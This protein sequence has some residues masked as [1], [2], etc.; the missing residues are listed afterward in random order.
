MDLFLE[1]RSARQF[2]PAQLCQ[3]T[4]REAGGVIGRGEDP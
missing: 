2:V 4:F 3:M 1:M